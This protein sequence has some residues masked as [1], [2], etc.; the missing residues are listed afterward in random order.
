MQRNR[1]EC[2][3]GKLEILGKNIHRRMRHPLRYKES[4]EL[5]KGAVVKHQQKL[6]AV[7]TETL[8]GMGNA[9]RKIPQI[10]RF[11]VRNKTAPILIEAGDPRVAVYNKGPFSGKMPMQF[12]HPAGS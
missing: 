3:G 10:A 8:D 11:D 12:A 9:G 2:G 1:F 7:G 4:V 6:G 5:R